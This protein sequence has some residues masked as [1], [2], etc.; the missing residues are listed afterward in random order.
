MVRRVDR[1]KGGF[2]GKGRRLPDSST[3]H[4]T[5]REIDHTHTHTHSPSGFLLFF[6]LTLGPDPVVS[7]SFLL[8]VFHLVGLFFG[9]SSI[10]SLFCFLGAWRAGR[11]SEDPM[12]VPESC[13]D[14][15]ASLINRNLE[16][17]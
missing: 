3:S 5:N 16:I 13:P 10:L 12:S 6:I 2:D 9:W 4:G 1:R 11:G 14:P 15:F 17:I 8:F 7:I